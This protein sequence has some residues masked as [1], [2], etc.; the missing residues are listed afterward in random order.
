MI[1]EK[2][3]SYIRTLD[4][5]KWK[6]PKFA[7][8]RVPT[9]EEALRLA[10]NRIG[11]YIE[12]KTPYDD[13]ALET[14]FEHMTINDAPLLPERAQ[15]VRA[16]LESSRS[17]TVE[18]T[19]KVIALV[20]KLKMEHQVVIQS[21]SVIACMTSLVEAP[22]IRT[23]LLANDDPNHPE[24]WTWVERWSRLAHPAGVNLDVNS[25][26]AERLAT[27]HG[28]GQTVAAWTVDNPKEI[29]RLAAMGVDA[30]ITNCPDT[31]RATL[32]GGQH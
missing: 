29:A 22:R 23:E 30:L 12:I 27:F 11:V 18:L 7:G 20:R 2:D 4:A 9:L 3:L 17:K 25:I 5:G 8:E 14:A 6:D 28:Q 13:S 16:C 1:C 32:E 10:K 26:T 31:T 21:F 19:Q 24:H 15:P